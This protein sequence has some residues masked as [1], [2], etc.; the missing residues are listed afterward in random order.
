MSPSAR[1][2]IGRQFTFMSRIDEL[3]ARE[4]PGFEVVWFGHIGDGNLHI[5]VLRP[6]D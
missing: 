6:Q 4:Y 3:F 5:N 1:P 2:A